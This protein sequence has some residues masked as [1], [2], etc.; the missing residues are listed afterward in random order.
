MSDTSPQRRVGDGE[1]N[2]PIP[3]PSVLTTAALVREN[4]HLRE[5]LEVK[6]VAGEQAAAFHREVIETRLGGMDKGVRLLQD[7]ADKFPSWVDE[8]ITA[9]KDIHEQR[10]VAIADTASE[11]FLSIEKQFAERDVR[12]EQAAGA[13]KIA[14]DAALQAQK[15]AAGEQNRS[16]TLAQTK[17]ETATTKQIDQ[18][19]VLIQNVTK[20]FDDKIGDVKDRLTRIEGKGEIADPQRAIESA[21]L[22][23]LR[24]ALATGGGRSEGMSDSVKILM[25]ILAIATALMG[26]YTFTQKGES[27]AAPQIIYVPAPAGSL[28]PTTPPQS[29]PR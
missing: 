14:V 15:E 11:K 6:L 10:F 12:T 21:E 17:S 25:T 28:L 1:S 20:A 18:L 16:N 9:L 26:A 7:T 23:Q 19:S 29:A 22:T 24:L 27:P 8:K 5:L 2:I 3:D 4:T 13:V